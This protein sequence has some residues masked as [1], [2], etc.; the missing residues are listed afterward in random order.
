M[1]LFKLTVLDFLTVP[2][3]CFEDDDVPITFEIYTVKF[4]LL[5]TCGIL[6]NPHELKYHIL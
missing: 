4:N 6:V 3:L 2:R 5:V 1:T